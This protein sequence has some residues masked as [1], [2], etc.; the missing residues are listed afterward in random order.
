MPGPEY[1]LNEGDNY[2]HD[3]L[4]DWK[5]DDPNSSRGIVEKEKLYQKKIYIF[6]FV[7]MRAKKYL[8]NRKCQICQINFILQ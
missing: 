3:Q 7:I 8:G 6:R 5:S 1:M 4:T 2:Y